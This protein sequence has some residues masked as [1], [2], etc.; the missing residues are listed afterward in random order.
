MQN[1]LVTATRYTYNIIKN[2]SVARTL[3][4]SADAILLARVARVEVNLA[5]HGNTVRVRIQKVSHTHIHDTGVHSLPAT[6]VFE[7]ATTALL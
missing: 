3:T 7:G 4:D 2:T 5:S 6:A 1:E